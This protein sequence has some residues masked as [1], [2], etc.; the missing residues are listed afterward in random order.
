MLQGLEPRA[1]TPA[2][3]SSLVEKEIAKWSK[4][5]RDAGIKAE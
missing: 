1:S 4:V 3:F 5:V 2:E